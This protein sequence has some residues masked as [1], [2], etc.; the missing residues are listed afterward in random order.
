MHSWINAAS[1][2][3]SSA[4]EQ[5]LGDVVEMSKRFSFPLRQCHAVDYVQ[6]GLALVVDHGGQ[7]GAVGEHRQLGGHAADVVFLD[8][9]LG[10]QLDAV[11]GGGGSGEVERD[12]DRG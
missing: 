4:S 7:L 5:R 11:A 6:G 1:S 9:G 2:A 10:G 8:P 3:L 12:G